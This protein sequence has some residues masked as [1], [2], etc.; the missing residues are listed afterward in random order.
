MQQS[1]RADFTL[2]GEA[3]YE[4]LTLDLARRWGADVIRDS[5]GTH[6]SPEITS[7]G[8]RVYSTICIIRQHNEFASAHPDAQQQTF[9]SSDPV[10]AVSDT[11]TIHPLDGYFTEQFELNDSAEALPYWQVWD[12]TE[13]T[14]LPRDAWSYQDGTVTISNCR[15]WHRYTVSFLCWRIWEEINM[16]NH[17]TNSWT[18]EHLRQLDPRHP[19]AW[20]YL[21]QWLE[22]WCCENPETNVVRLTSLF[23][24]FVWIFGSDVRRKSRFVDWASYDFTVSP[25]ALH[26]FEAEYGYALT[27]EDFIHLGKLQATHRPPTRAKLDYMSFTQ[28]FVAE[29]AKA[30]VDIIHAHGKQ[31]YVFYDDS[32]VGMEPYGKHFTSIGFDGLIKCVFS[33]FECRLC[34]GVDVPVHELRF[35]PYLFPVGLGGLPTFMDGGHSEKDAMDYWL[36]VRRALARKCVD[37]IGLGGYLHLTE[38][39]PAF[40]DTITEI[41]DQFRA[42]KALHTNGAPAVLPLTVGVLH[43][44]GAL[45]SWTLSGHFHETSN[46]VLIHVLEALSGLPVNVRFLSFDDVIGGGLQDVDVLLNAGQAGDAWSGGEV[47]QHPS[48]I[49]E[50]TRFVYEGGHLIG[51]DEPSAVH[52]LDTCL[53]LAHLFGVDLDNGEYACHIPFDVETVPAPFDIPESFGIRKTNVR[54]IQPDTDV[55]MAQG[56]IPQFTHHAFGKGHALYMSGFTYSPLNAHM[57]LQTLIHLTG[58]SQ[59]STGTSD[60]PE[61]ETAW[62][63]ADRTMIVMNDADHPICTEVTCPA[64]RASVELAPFELKFVTIC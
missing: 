2:P 41:S 42:I 46:H 30:L 18:S 62:F 31:A 23:Y 56:G 57:F 32:W 49:A 6:L 61:I 20:E 47:W 3:G 64:G 1:I 24:N 14:L 34:A 53:A 44:W 13:N 40:V 8:Y 22:R 37:R 54:L 51:I 36:H 9:L 38:G 33:G 29:K 26:A 17:T 10:T 12:R 5:D 52:G 25:A 15:P 63:P 48:L 43:V 39:F 45:R 21:K 50:I 35:H 16:Y 60:H 27:A 59:T 4:Q 11:L 7:A 58:I 19:L 28:R 55:W